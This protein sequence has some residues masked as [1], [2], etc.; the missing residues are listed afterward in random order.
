LVCCQSMKLES[1][2][3]LVTGGAVRIGRAIC[4]ALAARGCGVVVHYD[5]SRNEAMEL[6]SGMKKKGVEAF[7]VKMR[8]G[9]EKDCARLMDVAWK[10]AG[11]IDFLINNAA[12]FHKDTLLSTTEKKMMTELQV[13]F[14][15]P[16]WLTKEFAKRIRSSEKSSAAVLGKVIN[17]LDQRIAGIPTDCLPYLLSKKMLAEL[18]ELAAL[19]LAPTI[20]VNGVAP[21]PV[22][23]VD[24]RRNL[25]ALEKA[26][27]IP[28]TCRP[29]PQ[30]VAAAV[31]FLLESDSITGQTVFVDGGRHL[32]C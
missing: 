24:K 19:E 6:V 22:L 2:I 16:M 14:L 32:T 9:G 12:V 21:G 10:K 20:T 27:D 13:N 18:T 26:G 3:A 23:P 1:K 8:F 29:T 25:A 11:H 28:L 7:A 31:V 15:A 4:E 17:L 5:R 30:D